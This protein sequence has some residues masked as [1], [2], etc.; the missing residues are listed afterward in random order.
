ETIKNN[1]E[2]V[3]HNNKNCL[4]DYSK[5]PA[6]SHYYKTCTPEEL[7]R[8]SFISYLLN[9]LNFSKQSINSEKSLGTL[10]G[11]NH[12]TKN[13]RVDLVINKE[14]QNIL[15]VEFKNEN[16]SLIQSAYKQGEEYVLDLDIPYLM[17]CNGRQIKLYSVKNKNLSP[18]DE[19]EIPEKLL[20][21]KNQI[22]SKKQ[23][24]IF[25]DDYFDM[26]RTQK[27]S[28]PYLKELQNKIIHSSIN[29]IMTNQFKII[30]DLGYD[31]GVFKNASGSKGLPAVYHF[32]EI[33]FDDKNRDIFGI[34]I[35]KYDK[36]IENL[37]TAN[38]LTI[39]IG[40]KSCLEIWTSERF[41]KNTNNEII[42]T[43]NGS[44]KGIKGLNLEKCLD[45]LKTTLP[46]LYNAQ[47][48]NI[49]FGKINSDLDKT[50]WNEM[51]LNIIR[52]T[53]ERE[54]IKRKYKKL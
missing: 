2:I 18:I 17:L 13:K 24:Y 26:E 4:I 21:F 27:W 5:S 46:D 36:P 20:V 9:D 30:K 19:D 42:L 40:N 31:K 22:K 14:G 51:I 6:D 44:I 32:Y 54:K 35:A 34:G 33:E 39:G 29:G 15:I 25:D 41:M 23:N 53:I 49:V 11:K 10:G 47:Y 48:N 16:I 3:I 1:L 12:K 50:K 7:V 45:T 28:V 38:I 37:K 43:H 8:Q 52:F